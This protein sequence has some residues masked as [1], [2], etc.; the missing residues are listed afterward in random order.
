MFSFEYP[1]GRP[2]AGAK[3][4]PGLLLGLGPGPGGWCVESPRKAN[5][6]HVEP[7]ECTLWLGSS[8]FITYLIISN[9]ICGRNKDD[10]IKLD[11]IKSCRMETR[12]QKIL[13][14]K[15]IKDVSEHFSVS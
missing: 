3:L 5:R 14:S 4:W 12:K 13:R 15:I 7:A 2:R 11:K 9:K 10:L 8:I 1:G 6:T